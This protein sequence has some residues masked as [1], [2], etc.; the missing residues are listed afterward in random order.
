MHKLKPLVLLSGRSSTRG[1]TLIELLVTLTIVS[2]LSLITL[3]FAEMTVTR[4]KELELK[5]ALRQMRTAIDQFHDDVKSGRISKLNDKVSVNGFPKELSVLVQG[6]PTN[7]AQGSQ[8]RYLRRVPLNPF[9]RASDSLD[10]HWM[11]RGY[12]DPADALFW[13]GED[14]YDIQAI[15]DRVA[16]DG[17]QYKRW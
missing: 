11:L 15:T 1:F 12:Q 5:Q 13:N 3:P 4:T 7:N 2:V 10:K 16:I 8:R 6:L 14:V 9:A 17:S